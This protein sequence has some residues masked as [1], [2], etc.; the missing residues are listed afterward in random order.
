VL[1]LAALAANGLISYRIL[2]Q[3]VSNNQLVVHTLHVINE[4]DATLSALK[5][6]ENGQRGYLITADPAYLDRYRQAATEVFARI[7]RIAG[8]TVDN[9][10]Q[11]S[12]IPNLRELIQQ[13]L[14]ISQH[15]IDLEQGGNPE[16]ARLLV[17]GN[18]GREKMDEIR[19]LVAEMR[20]HEDHLLEERT[21]ASKRG[22]QIAGFAFTL[23]S[24]VAVLFVLAFFREARREVRQRE[25]TAEALR[26]RETWLHTTLHSIG[27]AVIATND[28]GEV[29]FINEVAAR[30]LRCGSPEVEGKPLPQIFP[31]FNE[32]TGAP[33]EN[34]VTSVIQTA[35]ISRLSNH[36][37]LRNHHGEEIPI[38]DSAA[39]IL[40][41]N[42]NL[43]GAV[44]V[45]R[46][47]SH[48]RKVE[49]VARISEKLA[50]TGRLAAT[51]AHEINNP[52]EAAINLVFL[53][54]QSSSTV[55]IKRY[56]S[57][58]DHELARMAHVTRKTLSFNRSSS[59]ATPTNLRYLLEEVRGIYDGRIRSQGIS[60]EIVCPLDLEITTIKGDLQQIASNLIANAL[61]ALQPGG[62]LKLKASGELNGA[63]LEVE[64]NGLGIALANLDRIFEPFFTTK[65][66][67]GTGLGL[68]VV[69]DLVEQQG[70]TIAV[71]SS[72]NG[73]RRGTRFS[74]F[75]PSLQPETAHTRAS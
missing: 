42:G 10:Y 45:F 24:L 50:A 13:R 52:L 18:L 33:A 34:P 41:R 72:T 64:D 4:L 23:A 57:S 54:Q 48:Q 15:S 49:E 43:T 21:E 75:L 30:L 14:H 66:D 35:S 47:V 36:T 27:D 37:V 63:K 3:L 58:A 69:K 28:K 68:W 59:A 11:Q 5:D 44:L 7:D 71:I 32:I 39:P 8:L 12:R 40:D 53:A 1:V 60:V 74:L 55:E 29:K 61:D 62:H 16:E 67:T 70:G 26:E 46:D 73:T 22:V 9:Q 31:I 17:A 51:I 2:R 65:K 38:E 19:R 25:R 20:T 6:A 56:L